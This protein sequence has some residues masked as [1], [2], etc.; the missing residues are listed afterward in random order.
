M[1][2]ASLRP[3]EVEDEAMKDVKQLFDVG[4]APYMVPLDPGG[5]IFSLEDDFTQ[6]DE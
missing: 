3:E 6:H 1:L 2:L 5:V 4:E